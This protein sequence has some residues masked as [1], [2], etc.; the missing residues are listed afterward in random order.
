MRVRC[1][2]TV[3]GLMNARAPTSLFVNPWATNAAICHSC[4]VRSSPASSRRR[5]VAPLAW[6]SERVRA[7]HGSAPSDS[8]VS[9]AARSSSRD[10]SRWRRRRSNSP[11]HSSVR[12]RA[13]GSDT[14]AWS[15]RARPNATS[16]LVSGSSSPSQ[17]AASESADERA[18]ERAS[19]ANGS[20]TATASLVLPS[21]TYAS[22]RSG[23]T[24]GCVVASQYPCSRLAAS[25]ASRWAIAWSYSPAPSASAPRAASAAA[26]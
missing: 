14:C 21:R 4:G 12:A 7:A 11:K 5:S 18:D 22:T 8:K 3:L 1:D 24:R 2:S 13:N 17:R 16:K 20:N 9:S 10:R 19:A 23:V 26:S 25:A 6:S 15:S